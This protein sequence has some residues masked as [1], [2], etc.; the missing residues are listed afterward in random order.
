MLIEVSDTGIGMEPDVIP[1][2][3]DAFEQGD[4]NIT[5]EFGGLGLGLAICKALVEKHGGVISAHSEGK[6][7][8]SWFRVELP[9]ADV[10]ISPET[11]QRQA[12]D[13]GQASGRPSSSSSSTG[14]N[15]LLVEDHAD[16]ARMLGRLLRMDGYGVQTATDVATA[17]NLAEGREFDLL[18]SDIGLPDGTGLELM[19]QLLLRRPIKGIVLSGFGSEEDVR[20]SREAGFVEHLTK[21]VRFEQLQATIA[22][23]CLISQ[24]NQ[25]TSAGSN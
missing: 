8:G 1:V 23:L 2:I 10:E 7:K 21:P 18:I 13:D 3:F 5:R 19:H 15:I 24:C 17:L 25:S 9:L 11:P 22:R 4:R 12:V 20:K 6:G 14:V 16:T